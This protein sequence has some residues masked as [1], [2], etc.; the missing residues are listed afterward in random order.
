MNTLVGLINAWHNNRLNTLVRLTKCLALWPIEHTCLIHKMFCD[1]CINWFGRNRS[2][3]VFRLC[4]NGHSG[5][6]KKEGRS[7]NNVEKS[8][9]HFVKYFQM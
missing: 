2:I 7:R 4:N 8:S 9:V 6:H 3:G 5:K 1:D